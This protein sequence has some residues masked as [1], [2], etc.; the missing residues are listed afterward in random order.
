MGLENGR[1]K[2]LH[3]DI[4]Q[5]NKKQNHNWEGVIKLLVLNSGPHIFTPL[6]YI[7]DN[8]N[9]CK[10]IFYAPDLISQGIHIKV[11]ALIL[12]WNILNCLLT[13]WFRI[14]I[15]SLPKINLQYDQAIFTTNSLLENSNFGT[16][17]G[18]SYPG[19]LKSKF[20]RFHKFAQ[21]NHESL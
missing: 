15:R 11:V 19:W 18:C 16:E 3:K 12:F 14:R 2:I 10:I 21:V 6:N 5:K 7:L 20:R 9:V 8:D 1:E 13:S 4:F 17:N